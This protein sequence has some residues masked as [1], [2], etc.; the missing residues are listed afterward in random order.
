M[1]Q[2]KRIIND[3]FTSNTYMVWDDE[4]DYCWLVDIGDFQKVTD[5]LPPNTE[6]RGVFLTH[7][8]FDHIYGANALHKAFPQ[9]VV[10]TSAYGQ[11]ELNDEKKNFSLYHET[12]FIY[13]G[14]DVSILEEGNVV[15]LY[16]NIAITVFATPGHCPS[17]LTYCIGNWLFTGDSYIPEVKVVTK[18]RKGNR[19]LARQSEERILAFAKGKTICPGHGEMVDQ[20]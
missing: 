10:Y 15:E 6:I 7:G 3:I 16:P 4:Y 20:N 13:E 8:H 18:L 2:V 1:L 14:K 19:E 5:A 9:C 11:E 12:S 17:C